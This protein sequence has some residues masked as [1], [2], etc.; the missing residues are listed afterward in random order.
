VL[1]GIKKIIAP[2]VMTKEIDE[3]AESFIRSK[4]A[5]PAFKGYRGYPSSVCTSINE[6]VVH[7]IP[8]STKLR[9]GDIISLDIGVNYRGFFG[10]AALTMP[11]GTIGKEAERLVAVTERALRAGMERAVAGNRI[12][13]ISA[14]IQR[15]AESEGFSVVRTFV[16]HG[17]GRELHEEPQI[18]NYGRPGEGPEIRE[19]MTLAIEPMVN[20]G[21]WE[22]SILKDGWTA[23]TKDRKLSAHF[24]HTVAVTKNGL[25]ILTKI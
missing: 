18:P 24:E 4:G 8:S 10:D 5:K 1:G 12:S 21:G 20:A 17:I 11:V 19:G 7:G 23:V 13:D 22:V 14:S 15:C 6:Q 9:N 2:G 3:F 25:K 16:G